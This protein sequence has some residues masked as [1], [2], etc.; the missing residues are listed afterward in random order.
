MS[1]LPVTIV[2]TAKSPVQLSQDQQKK[3]LNRLTHALRHLQC[4]VFVDFVQDAPPLRLVPTDD[5]PP[6]GTGQ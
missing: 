3:F 2:V 6:A 1:D 5:T 4:D